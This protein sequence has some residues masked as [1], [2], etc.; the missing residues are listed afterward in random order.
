VGR[1]GRD[2]TEV[3]TSIALAEVLGSVPSNQGG[4]QP[5][6]TPV[7]GG[8]N[9]FFWPSWAPSTYLHTEKNSLILIKIK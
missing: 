8:Y 6:T 2:G 9:A 4:S 1:R 5:P 7:P 3:L